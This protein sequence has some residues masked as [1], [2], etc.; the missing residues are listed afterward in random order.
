[1]F[2]NNVKKELNNAHGRCLVVARRRWRDV[3]CFRSG[4]GLFRQTDAEQ[5][6][7]E[8]DT[9]D[10]HDGRG[11]F[12]RPDDQLLDSRNGFERP[13]RGCVDTRVH[14]GS[15]PCVH[16]H[17]EHSADP[18][19]SFRRRRSAGLRLQFVQ[20]GILRMLPWIPVHLQAV[21]GQGIQAWPHHRGGRRGKRRFIGIGRFLRDASD[22]RFRRDITSVWHIRGGDA[23]DSHRHRSC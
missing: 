17:G 21:G 19:P 8:A 12:R 15:R 10:G 22:A 5:F 3:C 20:H 13:R 16:C 9:A 1:M 2:N 18:M 23:S 11:R 4:L 7:R 6:R 14:A